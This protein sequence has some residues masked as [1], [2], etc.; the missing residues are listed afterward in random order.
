LGTLYTTG[1]LES[2]ACEVLVVFGRVKH[3]FSCRWSLGAIM[4]EMLV[5]YPPVYSDEPMT[6]GRKV[7]NSFYYLAYMILA[8]NTV[9]QGVATHF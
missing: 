7:C 2:L 3:K 5:G 9:C 6:T 4:Y 1:F 8:M